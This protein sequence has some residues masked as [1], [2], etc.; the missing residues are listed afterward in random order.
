MYARY[1]CEHYHG[2]QI[3]SHHAKF[4]KL[5]NQNWSIVWKQVHRY[6]HPSKISGKNNK[7]DEIFLEGYRERSNGL[8]KL[9]LWKQAEESPR[10]K[11]K[12]CIGY[13]A[14]QQCIRPTKCRGGSQV[15][16][17]HCRIPSKIYMIEGNQSGKLYNMA[18]YGLLWC[19]QVFPTSGWDNKEAHITNTTGCLINHS[20]ANGH[21]QGTRSR[22]QPATKSISWNSRVGQTLQ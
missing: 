14:M 17:R 16:A 12:I 13:N 1:I 4:Q 11:P 6:L 10:K 7:A 8:W 2:V 18:G 15:F 21:P 20:Q 22:H 19:Q 3:S 9:P 5:M